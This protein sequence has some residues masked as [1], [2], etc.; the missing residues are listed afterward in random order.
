MSIID[1]MHLRR[2]DLN[3]GRWPGAPRTSFSAQGAG[4]NT[5]WIDPEHD[6]VVVWRWHRSRLEGGGN[7]QAELY[8][9]ILAAVKA[10][11]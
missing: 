9:R 4:N 10:G 8:R 6:L 11:T 5:I 1:A 2:I 7:P 3:P